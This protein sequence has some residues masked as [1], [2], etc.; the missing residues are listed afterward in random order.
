M[1]SINLTLFLTLGAVATTAFLGLLVSIHNH[2]GFTNKIFIAHAAVGATWAIV[3]YISVT[4][5]PEN[6]LILIRFALFFAVPHV[7]LF[8]LFVQNFP[9]ENIKIGK[10][11]LAVIFAFMSFEMILSLTPATFSGIKIIENQIV[12]VP[13]RLIFIF[14]LGLIIP[15]LISTIL[16]FKKYFTSKKIEKQQWFAIGLGLLLSYTLLISFVFLRVILLA[17]SGFVPYSPLFLLPIFIASAYAILRHHLFSIKIVA[18]ETLTFLLL[19][20]SIMSAIASTSL[21][22]IMLNVTVAIFILLFGI[23][24]IRSVLK[25]IEQRERA[26]KLTLELSAANEKLKELDKQKSQ[27][28]SFASHDLKSPINIIKQFATLI[29]DGTYKEP[30]KVAETIQKIKST[31]DRATHLV[32]D[33]LDIRKIEEGH[34]DY[35]FET[36]DIVA[37]V[38]GS[39]EDYTPLA[40]SEKNIE[41]SFES[42]FASANVKMDTT[43]LRQVIQNLLSNSLKYTEAGWIK[44]LLTEE[45]KSVLITVKDSGLG[46]DKQLVPIL[47]EQFSRDPSVAKKIQGTGLGLYISKQIVIAH[48]GE[49]WAE[50]EGKGFGS[51]FFVRL[52]KA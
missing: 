15:F 36:K 29:A 34:M 13:G 19:V 27:F 8:F 51:S 22:S 24:L 9:S 49:I 11:W 41:V 17:D 14:G 10:V 32:D 2:K 47:F 28:L 45:Q 1:E 37:F 30:A 48:H 18:A 38:K 25:E 46:M 3:N 52:P 35:T 5:S 26:E 43:R 16:V 12:P 42:K 7:Y 50:S 40:K 31:A 6:A 44:V 20:A 39:A 33:F 21:F 23:L 4:T